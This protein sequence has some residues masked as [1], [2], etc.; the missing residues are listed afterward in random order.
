M[1]FE[2]TIH[3]FLLIVSLSFV[4]D[5]HKEFPSKLPLLSAVLKADNCHFKKEKRQCWNQPDSS[6]ESSMDFRLAFIYLFK[7]NSCLA[8]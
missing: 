7:L 1:F 6:T 8:F 3:F 2:Q 4:F 5:S